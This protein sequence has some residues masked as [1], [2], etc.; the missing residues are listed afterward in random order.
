MNIRLEEGRRKPISHGPVR[1][2]SEVRCV[3]NLYLDA[4]CGCSS[5][6]SAAVISY[7]VQKQLRRK[8][9][10]TYICRLYIVC[11]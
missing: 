3:G 7:P 6:L 2:G 4:A 5:F 1:A 8:D 9:F 10:L 11:H